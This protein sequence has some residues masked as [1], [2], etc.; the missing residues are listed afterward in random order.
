VTSHGRI[1]GRQETS[2]RTLPLAFLEPAIVEAMIE[3]R[4]PIGLTPRTL[5][6]IGMLPCSWPEQRRRPG[7][8]NL[9]Q[10]PHPPFLR[11]MVWPRKAPLE[12]FPEKSAAPGKR[13]ASPSAKTAASGASDISRK[14]RPFLNSRNRQPRMAGLVV[15]RHDSNLRQHRYERSAEDGDCSGNPRFSA[16]LAQSGSE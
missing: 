11:L 12:T 15:G 16:S 3:G 10:R 13:V 4:Q 2:A 6:R 1:T 9:R 5:K 7:I 14:T 8:P